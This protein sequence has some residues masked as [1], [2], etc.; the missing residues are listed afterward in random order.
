LL[1]HY[2]K[3]Y[4]Y[5]FDY[6]SQAENGV[7]HSIEKIIIHELY[8]QQRSFEYDIALIKLAKPVKFSNKISKICI[9]SNN[10][11]KYAYLEMKVSGWGLTA[12]NK[13]SP[14]LKYADVTSMTNEACR[15]TYGAAIKDSMICASTLSEENPF[16][17]GDSG[18]IVIFQIV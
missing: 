5:F 1:T 8:D 9:P 16:R 13:P 3:R 2:T 10:N 15:I 11:F 6:L 12:D 17:S 7:V 14:M 4:S 18:G